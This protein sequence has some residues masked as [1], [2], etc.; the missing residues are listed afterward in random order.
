MLELYYFNWKGTSDEFNE[1]A[2]RMRGIIDGIDGVD[3]IGIFLPTSEWHYVMVMK[4]TSHDKCLQVLG[5]YLKKY[6]KWKTAL[7]KIELLHTFEE[8]AYK[9]NVRD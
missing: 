1:F 6:G 2:D 3:L 5:T 7:G 9:P 8:I 4:A